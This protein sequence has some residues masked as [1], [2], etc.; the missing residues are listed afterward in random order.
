MIT[1]RYRKLASGKYSVYLDCFDETTKERKYE[2][3][4]KY[5]TWDYSQKQAIALEDKETMQSIFTCVDERNKKHKVIESTGNVQEY[6]SILAFIQYLHNK[7]IAIHT[8]TLYKY[9]KIYNPTGKDIPFTKID[10][11]WIRR[12]IDYCKQNYSLSQVTI[13]HSQLHLIIRKAIENGLTVNGLSVNGNILTTKTVDG[14]KQLTVSHPPRQEPNYLSKDEIELLEN[15]T[16]IPNV[17]VKDAFLFSCYT[18]LQWKDVKELTWGKIQLTVNSSKTVNSLETVNDTEFVNGIQ[19]VYS[20]TLLHLKSEDSYTIELNTKAIAIL[21][22]YSNDKNGLSN[23]NKEAL[24]F[25]KLPNKPNTHTKLRLWG[26]QAGL[27]QDLCFSMA[28]DSFMMQSISQ[29][30][31]INTICKDLGIRYKRGV[32]FISKKYK[33][34]DNATI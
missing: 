20:L 7:N 23:N 19:T 25:D 9:L 34:H 14:L 5:V 1:I 30:K 28:R 17:S 32:K 16:V 13:L 29:N 31:S 2:F 6:K 15:S 24:V 4:K 8:V 22:Q 21:L 10:E 11:E 27:K 33:S 3:L 26:Y 12:F 18:G